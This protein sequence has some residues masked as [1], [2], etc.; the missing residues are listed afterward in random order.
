MSA[1][2]AGACCA[3]LLVLGCS[4]LPG[5]GP[6]DTPPPPAYQPDRQDYATFRAAFPE[7][8]EPN[9]LPFMAHQLS[10][11]PGRNDALV[12]CRWDD[13]EMPLPV[14]VAAPVIPDELQYEFAPRE[15]AAYVAAVE[16]A[17]SIWQREMDGLVRFRRVADPAQARIRIVLHGEPAPVVDEERQ[18]LGSTRLGGACEVEGR[19][20]DA[21]RLHVRFRVDALQLYV[22]DEFGLLPPDQVEWVALHEL[23]HTL[24]MRGHSPIPADLMYEVVRDRV[25]VRE[26][27]SAEDSNS[28]LS[29]YALPNGTVF[30][31]IDSAYGASRREAPPPTGPP[32]LA[33][34]PHVDSTRGFRVR[35]PYG[36]QRV[37]TEQGVAAVDGVTWDYSASYQVVASRQPSIDDYLDRYG[38]WYA[39]RGRLLG[40]EEL[41]VNGHPALQ[42]VLVRSD[43]QAVEEVT[44]IE[45]G[46]GRVVVVT[47]E[48]APD[49]YEA[50]APWFDAALASLEIE[51]AGP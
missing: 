29:L 31:E 23:G 1:L 42:G 26:G 40:T 50:Y 49:A 27:L 6:W 34:A 30:T 44:L 45:T 36:W 38:A 15:P 4:L 19:D 46:D 17:L 39:R 2:R 16:H 47:A 10:L 8:H 3:T 9:Y 18:V 5:A 35:L 37:E 14:H 13:A 21:D 25:M 7:L 43:N 32:M 24:G 51:P 28:F 41:V 22:A 33:L 48:C 11:G 12:F 20:P